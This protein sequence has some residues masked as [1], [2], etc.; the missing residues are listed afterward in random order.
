[1][2]ENA[3]DDYE[4][5]D[6]RW[7]ATIRGA[8][9]THLTYDPTKESKSRIKKLKAVK[10]PEYRLRAGEVRVFYDV[11]ETDV[12]VIAIMTKEKTVKWLEKHGEK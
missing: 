12:V 1:M 10:H 7:R 4:E 8:I 5:L 6:A 3:I 9:R 2:T 11:I